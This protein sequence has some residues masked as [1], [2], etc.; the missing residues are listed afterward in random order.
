MILKNLT[1][2]F[3]KSYLC[4]FERS[5]TRPKIRAEPSAR[6]SLRAL[7]C[8]L[9]FTKKNQ[10]GG[11]RLSTGTEKGTKKGTEKGTEKDDHMGRPYIYIYIYVWSGFF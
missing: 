3:K 10:S 5:F 8:R 6:R 9:S 11:D 4:F 2:N 7:D 1:Y